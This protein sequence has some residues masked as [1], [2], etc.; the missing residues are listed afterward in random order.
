MPERF[1]SSERDFTNAVIEIAKE[2]GWEAFH[3]PAGVYQQEHR[4]LSPGFPD[5]FLRYRDTENRSTC[6]V[7]ELKTNDIQNSNL[8]EEQRRFLEDLA[9]YMP[10][11]LWR[12]RDWDYIVNVLQ[13]GPPPAT[14]QIIE[15]SLHQ[16][17]RSG[18]DTW[19]PP[20]NDIDSIV[21]RLVRD[22]N[23]PH[24]NRG[25]LA[26]LRKINLDAP[27]KADFW[28]LMGTTELLP[29]L[30]PVEE[31]KW[32]L[33]VCGIALMTP[34]AH[35]SFSPVGKALFEG[36]DSNRRQAFYSPLRF[37]RLLMARGSTLRTLLIQMFRMMRVANQPFDW[38][39]M[40]SFIL[41]DSDATSSMTDGRLKIARDYYQAEYRSQSNNN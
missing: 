7:A 22:L 2:T 31:T 5:L 24:F 30:T 21:L 36:G 6:L 25:S 16:G 19:L 14:G 11:F 27:D 40:A 41:T 17:F 39:E 13:N 12:Y 20:K 23:D 32:A 9:A 18:N 33:V 29:H 38:V 37:N 28:R 3:I 10:T 35:D 15:P 8:S 1:F 4:M 34:N 26:E